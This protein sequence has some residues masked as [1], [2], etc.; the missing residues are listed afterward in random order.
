MHN[1]IPVN[2]TYFAGLYLQKQKKY[3]NISGKLTVLFAP[4]TTFLAIFPIYSMLNLIKTSDL[5]SLGHNKRF[6]M[7]IAWFWREKIFI[8][9]LNGCNLH[10]YQ[11]VQKANISIN[12]PNFAFLVISNHQTNNFHK[13]WQFYVI[14]KCLCPPCATVIWKP[15]SSKRKCISI[16]YELVDY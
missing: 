3:I 9:F 1:K 2:L 7:S 6:D 14:E 13:T 4:K 16:S 11:G 15:L 5:S 8:L 12:L 10:P